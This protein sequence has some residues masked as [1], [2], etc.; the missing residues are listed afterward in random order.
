MQPEKEISSHIKSLSNQSKTYR[1]RDNFSSIRHRFFDLVLRTQQILSLVWSYSKLDKRN[2]KCLNQKMKERLNSHIFLRRAKKIAKF[3]YWK[4][5]CLCG[6][7]SHIW[8]IITWLRSAMSARN[9]CSARWRYLWARENTLIFFSCK[10]DCVCWRMG[11]FRD[12]RWRR[13]W[14][15]SVS[16]VDAVA[17]VYKCKHTMIGLWM[18]GRVRF[19]FPICRVKLAVNRETQQAIAVKIIDLEKA[20]DCYDNVRKEV[21]GVNVACKRWI[22]VYNF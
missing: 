9:S 20:A 15:V 5:P 8:V 12:S 13:L 16:N 10:D 3:P 18:T 1:K 4:P 22:E 6:S 17:I 21:S 19:H 11:L 2:T 7:Y 14:R